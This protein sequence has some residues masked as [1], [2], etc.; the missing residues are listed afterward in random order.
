M[1]F[2]CLT[3]SAI[4]KYNANNKIS[5]I[6]VIYGFFIILHHKNVVTIGIE[7]IIQLKCQLIEI[8]LK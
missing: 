7:I 3:L 5:L 6:F 4:G 2:K 8:K 1:I